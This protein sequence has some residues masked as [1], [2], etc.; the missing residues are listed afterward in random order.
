MFQCLAEEPETADQASFRARLDARLDSLE[1][2]M[3][4]A[5]DRA[6]ATAISE[7]EAENGYRLL[8]AHRG[9]S[10]ALSDF[11]RRA[12][13]IDWPCLRAARF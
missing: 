3:Q 7:A 11:S 2:H 4:R 1:A 12:A 6:D 10:E 8:G 13:A 5:I 9:I